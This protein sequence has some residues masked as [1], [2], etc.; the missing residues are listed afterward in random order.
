MSIERFI[1]IGNRLKAVKSNV[2][3]GTDQNFDLLKY[4]QNRNT[5]LLL[6]GLVETGLLPTTTKPTRITYNTATLIDNIYLKGFSCY[7]FKSSVLET[8][9]SDHF[10]IVL[11]AGMTEHKQNEPTTVTHRNINKNTCTLIT[12]YLL[13]HNWTSL[14]DNTLD[15]AYD[16]FIKEVMETIDY[17]APLKTTTIP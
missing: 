10:P 16:Y 3:V 11:F 12:Q 9:I 8:D 4:C 15:T 6:D 14:Q 1:N 5:Q 7:S 17:Y 2:I 13:N